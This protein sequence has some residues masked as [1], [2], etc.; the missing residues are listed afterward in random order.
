[1]KRLD[2]SHRLRTGICRSIVGVAVL[3]A[4]AHMTFAQATSQPPAHKVRRTAKVMMA[5]WTPEVQQTLGV[6][7]SEFKDDGLG[8]LTEAQLANLLKAAAPDPK[9]QTLTCPAT[10]AAGGRAR[11][12]LTV[13]GDDPSGQIAAQIRRAISSLTGVDV[14]DS[15][16][17]ADR[18]LNVVI[19]EQTMGKRTIG[20]TASYL[21]GTPCVEDAAGKKTDVEL[22]GTLGTYT[23][24]KGADLA[25]DLAAMLD[26]DLRS[27]RAAAVNP[28]AGTR[29]AVR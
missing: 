21:T 1:M 15:A 13:S 20:F 19:Q 8:K 2:H 5:T 24:P 4:P 14:V 22:K 3:A 16:A 23:D 7:A 27:V 17:T 29:S 10:V 11:V 9:R 28:G 12:M 18:I 26:Q 25:R 6:S